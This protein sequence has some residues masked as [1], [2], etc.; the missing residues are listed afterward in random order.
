MTTKKVCVV[1]T[2]NPEKSA[3]VTVEKSAEELTIEASF[4]SDPDNFR[5]D[6]V[7]EIN[8]AYDT[9]SKTP[10]AVNGVNFWPDVQSAIRIDGARRRVLEKY[11]SGLITEPEAIVT[12]TDTDRIEHDYTLA[13]ALTVC[14]AVADRAEADFHKRQRKL[15]AINDAQTVEAL[16]AITWDSVES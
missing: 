5:D 10:L 2:K 1:D 14:L 16:Q 6:K 4:N 13:E 12:L 9:A 3:V 7:R 15:V 8:D 11:H